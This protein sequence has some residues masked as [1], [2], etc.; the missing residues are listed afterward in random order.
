MSIPAPG[1]DEIVLTAP[2]R[3]A[4]RSSRGCADAGTLAEVVV[5]FGILSDPGAGLY[6]REAMW[7]E[8]WRRSRPLCGACWQSCR[9]VAARCRPGL[10]VT[11]A[12][13]APASPQ[14]TAGG[15]P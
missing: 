11:G 4:L 2:G 15:R 5:A 7:R 13:R 9:Q 12:T 6:S 3:A 14:I 10:A 1:H 8:C